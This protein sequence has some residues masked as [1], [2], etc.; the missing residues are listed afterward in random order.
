MT[1]TVAVPRNKP[2]VSLAAVAVTTLCVFL[3]VL[4][5]LAFNLRTGHDPA[6]GM[7]GPA[8]STQQVVAPVKAQPVSAPVTRSSG[9]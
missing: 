8:P 5:F 1:S 9:G 7:A 3:V 4:T 6:L 2:R